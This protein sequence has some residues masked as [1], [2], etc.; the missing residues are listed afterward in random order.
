VILLAG[1]QI[2][3]QYADEDSDKLIVQWYAVVE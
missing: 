1:K 3:V 2:E